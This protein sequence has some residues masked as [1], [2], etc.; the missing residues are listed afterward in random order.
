MKRFL[1]IITMFLLVVGL[2][3]VATGI[4][5][6]YG[7]FV[8][9]YETLMSD[10]AVMPDVPGALIKDFNDINTAFTTM[11]NGFSEIKDLVS[12]FVAM[13]NFFALTWQILVLVSDSILIPIQWLIWCFSTLFSIY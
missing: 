5:G 12:F 13:G 10:F 1:C 9:S 11:T 7:Q 2:I 3:R 4:Y 6:T 8:P